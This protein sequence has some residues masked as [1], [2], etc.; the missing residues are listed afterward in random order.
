MRHPL[1]IVPILVG[2]LCCEFRGAAADVRI[3][4]PRRR[5]AALPCPA[6]DG[7]RHGSDVLCAAAD[8]R[9]KR[10]IVLG[11]EQHFA[12]V[13]SIL[14]EVMRFRSGIEL[15]ARGHLWLDDALCRKVH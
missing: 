4:Q 7:T 5:C 8:W 11:D 10:P 2:A 14:D 3:E 13:A 1:I 12:D 6:T 15:E 9:A